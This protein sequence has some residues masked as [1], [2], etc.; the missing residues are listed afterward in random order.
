MAQRLFEKHF[1]GAGWYT[2]DGVVGAHDGISMALYD[3]GAKCGQISVFKVVGRGIDVEA[4]TLRLRAAVHGVVFGSGDSLQ[5]VRIIA[6]QT[7]DEGNAHAAGEKWIF[8]VGLLPAAPARIA[9]YVDVRRP[10]GE[11]EVDA[12]NVVAN[13]LVV[14]GAGFGR[15][16]GRY[17]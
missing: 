10:D 12:V 14:L 15:D 7:L 3:S 8:A 11:P 4:M 5:I 1:A 17:L 16:H 9:K 6:L 2:I 13:S